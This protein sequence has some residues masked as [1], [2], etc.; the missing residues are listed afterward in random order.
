MAGRAPIQTFR[1]FSAEDT[2]LP[3]GEL[4]KWEDMPAQAMTAQK[5]E[6]LAG[7]EVYTPM[8]IQVATHKAPTQFGM[9][10]GKAAEDNNTDMTEL[11]GRHVGGKASANQAARKKRPQFETK[12]TNEQ[13]QHLLD[14]A[15]GTGLKNWFVKNWDTLMTN[16]TLFED[17]DT[18]QKRM[19]LLNSRNF[20]RGFVKEKSGKVKRLYPHL[21]KEPYTM[22]RKIIEKEGL[23]QSKLLLMLPNNVMVPGCAEDITPHSSVQDFCTFH[24]I[25]NNEHLE[26]LL[27]SRTAVVFPEEKAAA[28]DAASMFGG[29]LMSSAPQP[30]APAAAAAPRSTNDG[31]AVMASATTTVDA[32]AGGGGDDDVDMGGVAADSEGN[33][34]NQM[35]VDGKK[36]S[37]AEAMALAM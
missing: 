9:G 11:G 37:V 27:I 29:T 18:P 32:V 6:G 24:L 35:V 25:I 36:I 15:G 17:C 19:D 21:A 2:N 33:Q 13:A 3:V 20:V 10:R 1:F 31:G 8:H 34:K 22:R 23:Y 4:F 28:V 12:L 26:V 30:V 16:V 5:G 14:G 7:F